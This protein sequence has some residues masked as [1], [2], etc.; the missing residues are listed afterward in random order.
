MLDVWRRQGV[1]EILR[2]DWGQ[3]AVLAGGYVADNLV[4]LHFSG[5]EMVG[6]VSSKADG[7]ALRIEAVDGEIV[8]TPLAV[9][10]LK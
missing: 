2:E 6:A 1:D 7:Q 9:Q 8:Q 3:G 4:S 10:H 5:K